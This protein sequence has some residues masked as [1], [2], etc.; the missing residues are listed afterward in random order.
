MGGVGSMPKL[1]RN[2]EEDQA[3]KKQKAEECRRREA[4]LAEKQKKKQEL[5]RIEQSLLAKMD[6]MASAQPVGKRAVAR[7]EAVEEGGAAKLGGM[8]YAAQGG[9]TSSGHRDSTGGYVSKQGGKA[10]GYLTKL[11]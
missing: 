3:L 1:R 8:N 4:A 11:S 6:S 7:V 10:K 2:G 9:H 5:N